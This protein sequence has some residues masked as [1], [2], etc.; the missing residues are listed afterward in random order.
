MG[1]QLQKITVGSGADARQIAVL[2]RQGRA[3][4]VFWLGGFKSDMQGS[5]AE[6]L[7][8]FAAATGHAATR[9]DY[10]GHGRSG[11]D[12]LDGTISR[13]LEEALAVFDAFAQ[14]PQILVGSSMGGWLALL[15]AKALRER[16]EA[17]RLAG[18]I[19][20]APAVDMTKALMSDHFGDAE[21]AEMERTGRV[22]QP[23]DY[24]EEPY[25]LTKALIEDGAKHLFGEAPI[26]TGC[27]VHIIQGMEDTDV[28][29]SHAEKLADRLCFDDV[30]LTL[31]RD[32]DHRLS[33]PQDLERLCAALAKMA[34][35]Q[36]A[37]GTPE[38]PET[39]A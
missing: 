7:D 14:G 1:V 12:F 30:V 39:A 2:A 27:K 9:F 23:S 3:P 26:E 22:T 13:W 4:G 38:P 24:S 21:W 32:G 25:V 35:G 11:G 8:A 15:L 33:R 20:I 6:A 18:L 34:G 37:A 29:Y 17:G 28:P 5:K 19:L 10:S 16:G 36:D 31:V